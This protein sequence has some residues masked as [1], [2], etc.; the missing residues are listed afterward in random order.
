MRRITLNLA[1]IA[2]MTGSSV[3]ASDTQEIARALSFKPRQADVNYEKVDPSDVAQCKLERISRDDGKG[4]W[5]TGPSGQPLRWFVDTNGDNKPDRWCYYKHGVEVYRESDTDF[6]GTADEYRW[7]NTE[8]TRWGIDKDEDGVIDRWLLISAEEVTAEVIQALATKDA[9]RFE[10]LLVSQQQLDSLGLGPATVETIRSRVQNAQ[11]QFPRWMRDQKLVTASSRWTNFGADKP[12]L[13]PAGTEG[14]TKDVVVYENAVALFEDS[15]EARQL[16]VG[17]MI[18]VDGGWR[19]ASLPRL[20][21][22]QST[23][24]E[25]GVFFNASFTPKGTGPAV[26]SQLGMSRVMETLVNELQEIDSKLSSAGGSRELWHSKR[27]DVLEKLVAHSDSSEDRRI[28]I[29][30]LADTVSAAAQVGEYP[31][32]VR[33]LQE[34]S[35]K[36][37]DT[38]AGAD[39]VAYVAFR[40]IT[41]DHNLKMQQPSAK[42]DELNESYLDQLREF[43]R[44]YPKS[45][46]SAEAM[47]QIALSAEFT[48]D[49][50]E[51]T[52]WYSQASSSFASTDSGKKAAG[53][54]RRI[55]L[56][57]KPFP[58]AGPTLDDRSFNSNAYKGGPVV[59]HL[60][61]SW[62]ESCKA[63]MRAL[64]E[65]QAKYAR[66]KLRIVGLNLDNDRR[67]AIEFTKQNPYPWINVHDPGGLESKLAVNF[68][69]LTLPV[70]IVVD[71]DG[72]VVKSGV[73]WTDLDRVIQE[74]VK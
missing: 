6:N 1:L 55:N 63:D 72:N 45:D 3:W 4:F 50:K 15:G 13:V 48:G 62:C 22:D 58:I 42:Y 64:K 29:E 49:M 67:A 23:M 40:T 20:V 69:I 57:G 43:I 32:G 8:G 73:H 47:L 5:I 24:E 61:A 54:I 38:E 17:T 51:A 71:K 35:S 2:A 36:L 28:W 68:G 59:Y 39:A 65:L 37:K 34:F 66:H 31:G 56:P 25:S 26:D 46:D 9:K 52:K 30:Q 21:G 74:I 11:E 33:R 19:L 18:Q 14:S 10:R 27:A 12:G 41:A 70:N 44:L 16:I 60:W 53:A 7:L